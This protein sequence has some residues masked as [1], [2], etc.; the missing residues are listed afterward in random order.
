MH[1]PPQE[2]LVKW[3]S[4][5]DYPHCSETTSITELRSGV[6]LCELIYEV[7]L[8]RQQPEL[9]H[10]VVISQ[11]GRKQSLSNLTLALQYVRRAGERLP[12]PPTLERLTAE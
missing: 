10:Q 4:L 9:L 11:I 3:V 6:A 8:N 7:V 1:H 2:D 5:F 12:L